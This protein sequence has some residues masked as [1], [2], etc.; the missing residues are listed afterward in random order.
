MLP[1]EPFK[2]G[3]SQTQQLGVA[4]CD[5]R[6]RAQAAVEQRHLAD[7]F[8][9]MDARDQGLVA[10]AAADRHAQTPRQHDVER[11]GV[12]TLAKQGGAAGYGDPFQLRFEGGKRRRIEGAEQG[13]A[14]QPAGHDRGLG[15][16]ALAHVCGSARII[17]PTPRNPRR[18][19]SKT[20][21]L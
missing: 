15:F 5:C 9:G 14:G 1:G 13:H 3:F 10:L 6:R 2:L 4:Q 21:A 20:R 19:G 16:R 8:A 17:R 11:V 18:S 7:C 12:V